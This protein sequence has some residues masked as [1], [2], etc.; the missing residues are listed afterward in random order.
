MCCINICVLCM[1]NC[2]HKRR[3]YSE[4]SDHKEHILSVGPIRRR[5]ESG[6]KWCSRTSP[7]GEM[8]LSSNPK[9]FPGFSWLTC[10]VSSESDWCEDNNGG[11]EQI[12]TSKTTGP[13][14]SCVTGMLQRDGKTCR[15][16]D[17]THTNRQIKH[18]QGHR[19]GVYIM[20]Q[21]V[22]SNEMAH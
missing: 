2:P 11:C 9:V 12:C 3:M 5:G 15:S 19:K 21:H 6:H 17:Q 14:C 18:T 22:L 7:E 16:K 1:Q 20:F 13:V 10:D 4:D 8:I